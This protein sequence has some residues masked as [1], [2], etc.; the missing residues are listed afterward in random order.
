M[1]LSLR[2]GLSLGVLATALVPQGAFAQEPPPPPPA[3]SVTTQETTSEATGPSF[4]MI[5]S[6]IVV[7][8]LAYV[9]S[10]VA[11]TSSGLPADR[12]LFVPLAG[13]WIDL[14]QRPGCAPATQCNGENTSKVLLVTDGIVQ[15]VGALTV[16]GGLLTTGHE[17]TTVQRSAD[18][19]TGVTVHF[20]PAS[21]GPGYGGGW[22]RERSDYFSSDEGRGATIERVVDEG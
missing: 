15:G 20:T 11:A 19:A 1:K 17:T 10:V 4:A 16:L 3:A 13:P 9:P 12:T 2:H 5:A 18:A 7:F 14:T 22:R 6:G 21:V 8:G